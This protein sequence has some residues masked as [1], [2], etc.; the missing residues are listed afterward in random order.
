MRHVPQAPGRQSVE[1]LPALVGVLDDGVV[2][3]PG[4]VEAGVGDGGGPGP[5]GGVHRIVEVMRLGLTLTWKRSLTRL[6]RGRARLTVI[7]VVGGAV[8]NM[9]HLGLEAVEP[10]PIV[11]GDGDGEAEYEDGED[12][13]DCSAR[14]SLLGVLGGGLGGEG[15]LLPDGGGAVRSVEGWLTDT[16]QG[17][18]TDVVLVPAPAGLVAVRP[19]VSL[20]T[21]LR[22]PAGDTW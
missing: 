12:D 16:A 8:V 11:D 9:R 5:A 10:L 2:D 19:E 13:A 3:P 22:T 14:S 4:V 18:V 7:V 21:E 15:V 20:R 17:G 6:R 1:L